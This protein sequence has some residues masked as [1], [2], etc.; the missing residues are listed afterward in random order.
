MFHYLEIS[1]HE[2]NQSMSHSM[3][4]NIIFSK[5]LSLFYIQIVLII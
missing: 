3:N 2:C 4:V 1:I 5:L